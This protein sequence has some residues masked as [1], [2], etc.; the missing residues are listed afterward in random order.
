MQ[1]SPGCFQLNL[2][3]PGVMAF[4]LLPAVHL[5]QQKGLLSNLTLLPTDPTERP[6]NLRIHTQEILQPKHTVGSCWFLC[7]ANKDRS[8]FSL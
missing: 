3:M 6:R 2:L 7:D 5:L 8:I 4:D 1:R